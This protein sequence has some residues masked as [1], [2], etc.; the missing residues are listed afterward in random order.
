MTY[1]FAAA[2]ILFFV[3]AVISTWALRQK[4]YRELREEAETDTEW[5]NSRTQ[6]PDKWL[7]GML[8]VEDA[9]EEKMITAY[10]SERASLL[11][12][13][14]LFV[15]QILLLGFIVVFRRWPT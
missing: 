2:L 5:V 1:V 14:S 12:V 13:Q 6:P 7:D 10:M 11:F 8:D 9:V 15:I 4:P 3:I